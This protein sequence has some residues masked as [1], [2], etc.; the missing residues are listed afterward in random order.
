MTKINSPSAQRNKKAILE[1]LKTELP[2]KHRVLEI[3]SGT[4]Q[5]ACY[6]GQ[7]FPDVVWQPTELAENIAT[8][9]DWLNDESLRNV[10]TP[11]V[12][13]V[14]E[15][16]WPVTK[17]DVCFTCNTFH[18]VSEES[19]HSIFKSCKAVLEPG[20]KLI[21][22]GP[23]SINGEHNSE[24]NREFD[25]S[26]RNTNPKSGIRD[27]TELDELASDYNYKPSRRI[28]MPANNKIAIWEM[29]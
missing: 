11:I 23:F 21:V 28:D 17:A 8:I 15:Q 10:L 27:L 3:G 16:P 2:A 26:L 7:A 24:G 19:V 29:T 22:Y 4:G 18:I 5:H 9:N 25:L 1:I 14:D 6:F 20:G 13:D 12:L